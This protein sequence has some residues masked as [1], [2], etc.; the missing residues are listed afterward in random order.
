[1]PLNF[2]LTKNKRPYAPPFIMVHST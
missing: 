2:K 1:M